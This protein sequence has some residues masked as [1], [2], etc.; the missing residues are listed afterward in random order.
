MWLYLI[1][2]LKGL[3]GMRSPIVLDNFSLFT[4]TNS[5]HLIMMRKGQQSQLW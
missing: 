2:L 5:S 4:Q 1:I 3:L